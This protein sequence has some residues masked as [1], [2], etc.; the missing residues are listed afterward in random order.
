MSI[1]VTP[2]GSVLTWGALVAT[3]GQFLPAG[4]LEN[5]ASFAG[6]NR[7]WFYAPRAGVLRN[8][9]MIAG[10]STT[11][12]VRVNGVA[13]ALV[14]TGATNTLARDTTT[15]VAVNAEDLISVQVSGTAGADCKVS[16][17]FA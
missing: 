5:A 3:A 14:L 2:A 9:R 7:V 16:C 17:E 11:V 1:I 15:A 13:S 4:N 10:A 6:E 8:L 12:T